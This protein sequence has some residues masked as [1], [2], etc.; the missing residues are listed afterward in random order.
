MISDVQ[1]TL[2]ANLLGV[3]VFAMIVLYHFIVVNMPKSKDA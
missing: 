1:L 3:G 2:L